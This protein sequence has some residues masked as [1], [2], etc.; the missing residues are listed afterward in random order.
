MAGIQAGFEYAEVGQP[1]PRLLWR[2]TTPYG[3]TEFQIPDNVRSVLVLLPEGRRQLAYYERS[4]IAEVPGSFTSA[5]VPQD[6]PVA[7]AADTYNRN[8]RN[9]YVWGMAQAAQLSTTNIAA[10]T[11]QDYRLARTRHWLLERGTQ[12]PEA[13]SCQVSTTL[14]WEKAPSPD[15]T[16]E[17]AIT[18]YGHDGKDYAWAEGTSILPNLIARV[19]PDGSTGYEWIQRNALGFATARIERWLDTGNTERFRTNRFV[20]AANGVDVIAQYG[21]GDD[22]EAGFTYDASHPHL[23]VAATNAVGE[24]TRYY[25]DTAQN[26]HRLLGMAHASGLATTNLYTG[27]WLERTV[28][29]LGAT[30][31]RTNLYTWLDGRV[32]T[33]TDP[34]GLTLTHTHDA[35]G[36]LT[37]LDF[38]DS[39][40]LQHAYTNGA[41][42]ML[43]DRTATRDRLG[44]WSYTEYNGLR[45][46][47]RLLDPLLRETRYTYCGSGGPESVTRAYGTTLAETTG[48]SYDFAGRL[49]LVTEPDGTSV[50][51]TYDA[52]GRL[53]IV[54][55]AYGTSTHYFDNLNRL[56][57]VENAAGTVSELVYDDHDRVLAAIDASAVTVTN[58]YD[59]LGRLLTRTLPALGA[60]ES[61]GYTAGVSGPTAYTNQVGDVTL[62]AYDA[63]G[64]KT[65]E[66]QVGVFTNR[67][68]YTPAGDLLTLADGKGS[69]T[70]WKYDTEGRVTEKWYQ[71]QSTADLL[72]AYNVNGWLTSRFTRTGTGSSTNGYVTGYAFD[73]VGNLTNIAYPTG[74]ASITN[75]FDA[76]NRVTNRLDGLGQTKYT[77]VVLGNGQRTFAEDGPWTSDDVTVTNRHGRRAGLTI[78]QSSGQFAV[79]NA[80]DAAGRWHVVGGTAGTFTYGY[81]ADSATPLPN[82][83]TLPGGGYIT[84][85]H[86]AVARLTR[87]ELRTSAGAILN[88]HGYQYNLASQRTMLGRTNSAASS[89]NGYVN[90]LYDPAGQLTNAWTYLA[91]GTPVTTEKWSYGY[92]AAQNLAKRTNNTTVETFTV[93]ALNQL[94]AIPDSTPSYDRRGNLTLRSFSVGQPWV[95]WS[96]AYDAENQ[97]TSVT[98]DTAYTPAYNRFKVEFTYD[99]QGRLRVKK[100]YVW[101]GG[102]WYGSG[103][104]TRY[105]YDGMLVIQD[106]DGGGTPLVAYTRGRDLSGGYAGAGGIGGLLARSHGYSSGT[107]SSHHFYHADGNGNVTALA[108]S[109]GALQASYKYD[110]YGRYRG[111]LGTLAATNVMR[112]SSK[113]W[114]AFA[115]S[116][117][118]GLYYYGYRF[119]DPYLQRWVN[120]DPVAEWGGRNLYQMTAN[121]LLN[122]YD[123]FGLEIIP[124]PKA[125]SPPPLRLPTPPLPPGNNNPPPCAP[126]PDC[127]RRPPSPWSEWVLDCINECRNSLQTGLPMEIEYVSTLGMLGIEYGY[128]KTRCKMGPLARVSL[129]LFAAPAVWDSGV[130]LGCAI[131][132]EAMRTYYALAY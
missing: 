77:Y 30:P 93:N 53:A 86:D 11:A 65:N 128:E 78:A 91:N 74:T 95:Y 111:Q 16:Q 113:P 79:T 105:L 87:T 50:T 44:N 46:V 13:V 2:V 12:Y 24:I 35:L 38:P 45:Q 66:V 32:R 63:A 6:L 70:T 132:C 131:R 40:Y 18:W 88:A 21:P 96:Y 73:S 121:S 8:R 119:Y 47:T 82:A 102:G 43:L 125:P 42:V 3:A 26:G 20:Y 62:H 115:G 108:S 19:M 39:T 22:L 52:V 76:L 67:F 9:S 14:A 57:V 118:A 29:F 56:W 117:T 7:N 25:Y 60:V 90:A 23:P 37:R 31:L 80:W 103:G 109:A 61:F 49:V 112:F 81:P 75:W 84:N 99:G 106:R 15:G 28:D 34:R 107:W 33:H 85:N 114:V 130:W 98:T 36:R 101:S 122:T 54:S 1:S 124:F 59:P 116:T 27:A 71:G 94:T 68:T 120:R 72:Y 100:D 104:E 55:R 64:R 17:G 4:P 97:L 69:T 83:L 10:L 58:S 48:Y 126:Y 127:L 129:F 92:D 110:P 89:W 41:G 5:E 123:A 51:N